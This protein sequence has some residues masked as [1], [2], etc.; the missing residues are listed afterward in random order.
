MAHKATFV[1][2]K[3]WY[4]CGV[5]EVA[6]LTEY[7]CISSEPCQNEPS[8]TIVIIMHKMMKYVRN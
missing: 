3:Y 4:G 6:N 8:L 5:R 7:D 2:F 1:K